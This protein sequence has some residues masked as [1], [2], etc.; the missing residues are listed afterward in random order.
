MNLK[1][2]SKYFMVQ[3]FNKI[4]LDYL[5]G[6]FK[7]RHVFFNDLQQINKYFSQHPDLPKTEREQHDHIVE[8]FDNICNNTQIDFHFYSTKRTQQNQWT[9]QNKKTVAPAYLFEYANKS[10]DMIFAH[11]IQVHTAPIPL[12]RRFLAFRLAQKYF[13]IL[14]ISNGKSRD[15]YFDFLHTLISNRLKTFKGIRDKFRL[16]NRLANIQKDLSDKEKLLLI[17]E[18]AVKRKVYDLHNLVEASNEIYSILNFKQLI[19]SA[20]LTIIG[21]LGIQ[22]AFALM[23][24]SSRHT[25]SRNFQKGFRDKE[26]TPLKFKG[27]SSLAKYFLSHEVP[28]YV[29]N[30]DKDAEQKK[31]RTK[32]KKLNIH[33][34]APIIYSERLQGIIGIGGKLYEKEFTQTDFE[35][36][37]VLVNI[38]SISIENSLHYEEVKNLSLTDG[39]TN[40]HN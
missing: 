21:Q 26:I 37:H 20:L 15:I 25:F 31:Y 5:P 33:I 17:A 28:F 36:F 11:E 30:L 14:D 18:R 27:E 6:L 35:L 16:N 34:L 29:E 1:L 32:L 2:D 8:L 3:I 22:N 12:S 13:Y 9:D 7:N 10:M 4:F 40:L 19:N 24:D 38:I 39:M 23:F